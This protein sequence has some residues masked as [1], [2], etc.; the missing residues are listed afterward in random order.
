[1]SVI[2]TALKHM[3]AAGMP[4]D[5]IVAAVAEMEALGEKVRSSG[6]TR[7]ER[8]RERHKA[9]QSVTSVTSVTGDGFPPFAPLSPEPP[10]PP[11]SPLPR[12][13]TTCA[14]AEKPT[15]LDRL[16]VDLIEAA[17]PAVDRVSIEIQ[18]MS[19]P[20]H[21]LNAGCDRDLDIIPAVRASAA[22]RRPQSVRS[23]SYFEKA[24]FEARDRR[25]APAPAVVATGPRDPPNTGQ[26]TV[27]ARMLREMEANRAGS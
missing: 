15:D 8:Y 2:A 10:I 21:W 7:Q 19:A 14:G 27:A 17:G 5:S 4:H 9:S 6:A 13:E 20:W 23:W 25:L 11:I 26:G 3:L 22:G 24:V 18:P 16:K 1:M 12:Y